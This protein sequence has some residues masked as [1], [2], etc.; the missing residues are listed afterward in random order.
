[1][2]FLNRTKSPKYF[3][4]LFYS[5]L[6][7]AGTV[8][9][10]SLIEGEAFT[11]NRKLGLPLVNRLIASLSSVSVRQ[12][13]QTFCKNN[14]ITFS[15]SAFCQARSNFDHQLLKQACLNF[16]DQIVEDSTLYKGKYRLIGVDGSEFPILPNPDEPENLV[17]AHGKPHWAL[18]FNA[19]FDLLN[20]YYL[21]YQIQSAS[22]KN[23][24]AA[25]LN[26]VSE[27]GMAGT[28]VWIYD[29]LYFS[30]ELASQ[31]GAK[32]HKFIFRMKDRN[33]TSLLPPGHPPGQEIDLVSSRI[34][35]NTQKAATKSKPEVYK[36]VP[37]G[38]VSLITEEHPELNFSY[39][40]IIVQII[41]QNEEDGTPVTTTEYLLTNL[42]PDEFTTE[43][44]KELY[45]LRWNIEVSFR[46]LK[47]VLN[48]KQVH[49]RKQ[50]QIEQEIDTAVMVYNL[51]SAISKCAEPAQSGRKLAYQTNR[52]ALSNIVLQFLA[53]KATQKEVIWTIQHVVVPIRK[54]RHFPRA[55]SSTAS[56]SN[57][58]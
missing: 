33:C 31:I 4:S 52:K 45:H 27:Y 55:K 48:S 13:T 44:I 11:R 56:T 53:G 10:R 29:R 26:F 25:A 30:F 24:N 19:A 17:P 51:I 23:E 58:K 2:V 40:I 8:P 12:Q 5:A 36:Y 16:T 54:N 34:L 50:N 22:K 35:L 6:D 37:K 38:K 42:S 15:E 28:P 32:G 41:S 9:D 57:W 20:R 14:H 47:Y 21:N 46:D 43:D 1:M 3:R 7:Q 49:S 39:R 18:H